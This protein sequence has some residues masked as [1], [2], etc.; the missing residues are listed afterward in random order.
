[1]R[2]VTPSALMAIRAL[3]GFRPLA[4]RRLA[5]A[6]AVARGTSGFALLVAQYVRDVDPCEMLLND[7]NGLRSSHP[8]DKQAQ[9]LCSFG[10]VHFAR[11][12]SLIYR[13]SVNEARHRMG[14]RLAIEQPADADLVV[15]VPDSGTVAAI[16]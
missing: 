12:D 5:D 6:W 11:P 15:P 13:Q 9:R 8:P 4:R 7:E 1:M 2:F 16:G 3:R 10:H 14:A